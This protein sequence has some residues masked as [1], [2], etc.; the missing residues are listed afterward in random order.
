MI[1]GQNVEKCSI[2]LCDITN[3]KTLDK[4]G[5]SFCTDC[6]DV[7]FK[8]TRECPVC[9]TVYGTLIGNQP[10]G[11]M[12]DSFQST[13]LPGFRSCGTIIITYRFPNGIQ[14]PNH[15]N[16]GKPYAGT[17]RNAY[18]PDNKEGK[19]V[20]ELLRKAFDQKLTFTIGRSATTG[21]DN[22]VIWNDIHHKTS[23]TGGPT[24]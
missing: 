21:M 10:E 5:H 19:K 6:I 17:D 3:R 20:L 4:C 8:F 13:S 23:T 7:V 14:G 12:F 1:S 18:L 16:P 22:C 2:C 24:S 15:P 11:N 9:S